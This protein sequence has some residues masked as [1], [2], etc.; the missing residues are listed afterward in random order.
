MDK[1]LSNSWL[2]IQEHRVT[3]SAL[4]SGH[5]LCFPAA[6]LKLNSTENCKDST[7]GDRN[8]PQLTS[9]RQ[10]QCAI[11][12]TCP[13]PVISAHS[14]PQKTPYKF[15]SGDTVQISHISTVT[16]MELWM[17]HLHL[18]IQ[19]VKKQNL[20]ASPFFLGRKPQVHISPGCHPAWVII[21]KYVLQKW[22]QNK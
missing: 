15:S 9:W 18:Y 21:C 11:L 8:E 13:S 3:G 14:A 22:G 1:E 4:L 16:K 6:L 2:F 10:Q 12:P 19:T 17:M 20:T 5:K 7:S